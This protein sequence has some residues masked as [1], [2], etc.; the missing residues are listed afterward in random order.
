M[1][2][3]ET[4]E[5]IGVVRR[6]D[7]RNSSALLHNGILEEVLNL[8]VKVVILQIVN[9]ADM[10]DVA[11]ATTQELVPATVGKPGANKLHLIRVRLDGF[12]TSLFRCHRSIVLC[13][14][15]FTTRVHVVGVILNT[16]QERVIHQVV[17]RHEL[18]ILFHHFEDLTAVFLT[19]SQPN[20]LLVHRKQVFVLERRRGLEIL[21]LNNTVDHGAFKIEDA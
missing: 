4:Q 21:A 9:D 7:C 3:H 5:S 1:I 15:K 17:R 8:L 6:G 18:H 10:V 20:L 13:L 12:T 19:K 14:V 11:T 2:A 16:H